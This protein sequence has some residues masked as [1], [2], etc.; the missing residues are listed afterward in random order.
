MSE[1]ETREY[2][3]MVVVAA[4]RSLVRLRDGSVGRL[5]WWSTTSDLATV[6]AD[7]KHRRVSKDEV[8]EIVQD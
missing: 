4:N 6:Y 3:P 8:T 2:D 1:S 5:L 7:G